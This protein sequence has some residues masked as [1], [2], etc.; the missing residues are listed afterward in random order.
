MATGKSNEKEEQRTS[1]APRD[2]K[3]Q[4]FVFSYGCKNNNDVM[5][6]TSKEKAT[7]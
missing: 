7:S 4:Q 1:S 2:S 6:P 5:I 3:N